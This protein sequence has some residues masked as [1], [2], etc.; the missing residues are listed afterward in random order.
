MRLALFLVIA[1]A[2]VAM[3]AVARLLSECAVSATLTTDTY[4]GLAQAACCVRYSGA[5]AYSA[6]LPQ[7]SPPTTSAR[8]HLKTKCDG[9]RC[10]VKRCPCSLGLGAQIAE[11]AIG[12]ACSPFEQHALP[13]PGRQLKFLCSEGCCH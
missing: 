9:G 5:P 12:E 8:R 4:G 10:A 11:A 1:I 13:P 7:S 6:S 3:P 2:L